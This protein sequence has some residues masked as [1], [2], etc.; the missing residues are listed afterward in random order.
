MVRKTEA[1]ILVSR[2]DVVGRHDVLGENPSEE[3]MTRQ[4]RE[5]LL[6]CA[7]W[8]V[9]I[10]FLL[11]LPACASLTNQK[12]DPEVF[13]KR[14][15]EMKING[16]TYK[17]VAV[18]PRAETYEIEVKT[19]GDINMLTV[20]SCHREDIFEEPTRGW[21]KANNKF[22]YSYRPL[23]GI[24]DGRGCLLDIGS[25][26]RGKGRHQWAT[27]DFVTATETLPATLTCDGVIT[28]AGPVSIC[29]AKAGLTQ[30]IRFDEPVKVSPD[31]GCESNLRTENGLLYEYEATKG[32]C[33]LY[34]G[35]RDGRFHRH[36]TMGYESIFVRDEEQ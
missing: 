22:K 5:L 1:K 26:E 16:V 15:M 7:V 35:T 28:K 32:E 17:G 10:L 29:Q 30:R 8:L 34:F 6:A 9:V 24:E 33:L 20:T 2:S 12:L 19:V 23:K 27:I 36:V 25:Y 4:S 21:F 31:K 3:S 11:L 14:D 13:Y 18:P